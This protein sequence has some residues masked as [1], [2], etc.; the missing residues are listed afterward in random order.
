[1]QGMLKLLHKLCHMQA[2]GQGMVCV[3]RY[4]HGVAAV[5]LG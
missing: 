2:V 1:M 4:W 5:R 3:N